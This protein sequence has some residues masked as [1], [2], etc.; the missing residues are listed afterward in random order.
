MSEVKANRI[1]SRLVAIISDSAAFNA[2]DKKALSKELEVL[3]YISCFLHQLNLVAGDLLCHLS[4][5][6]VLKDGNRVISVLN[7][8]DMHVRILKETMLG[9]KGKF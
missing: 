8:H 6:M 9:K 4:C 1:N 7:T 2:G 3:Q 5:K